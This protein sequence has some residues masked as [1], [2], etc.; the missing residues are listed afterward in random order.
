MPKAGSEKKYSTFIKGFVTEASPLTYPA[1]ASLDEDNFVLNRNGSRE[2]RLGI[3]YETGY[4]ITA[5]GLPEATISG[6]KQSYHRWDSPGGATDVA[7]GIVRVYDKLWFLDLLTAS[8]SANL[9]NGGA[10]ISIAGLANAEIETAVINNLLVI[11]SSDLPI[12]V[13]LAYDKDL[14]EVFQ[15]T[16]P[17]QIRDFFGVNDGL[18]LDDRPSTLTKLHEYNLRNQGWNNKIQAVCAPVTTPATPGTKITEAQ[19]FILLATGLGGTTS[20]LP[21]FQKVA[22]APPLPTNAIECT[23]YTLGVYPSNSDIWTLGKTSDTTVIA[24]FEKY[25]PNIL[26]KN[27]V[28]IVEAPKGCHIIDAFNRGDSRRTLLGDTT[29]PLDSE[30]G[31]ISTVASYAGRV[32][33]SGVVSDITEQDAKSPNYSNYIFFSQIVTTADK[34]GK[35]YQE[36]DPTSPDISDIIDTDGGIIQIPE[37]TRIYRIMSTNTSLLV[38]AENGVWELFGDTQG[39]V[40]TSYQTSKIGSV[41]T[42]SPKSFVSANGSVLGFNKA[43]IYAY[44]PDQV[45]GRY[46]GE[47]ISLTSIQQF[48]NDLSSLAKNNARGFYDEKENKVRWL[49]NDTDSYA[50]GVYENRYNRELILDLTLQAF[51]PHTIT[52]STGPFVADYIDIPRYAVS[53][54]TEPIYVGT[55]PVIVTS[56]DPVVVDNEVITNRSTQFA[57]LTIV[58]TGFTVSKYNNSSFT[59]WEVFFGAGINY[60]S[61]LLTGYEVF[62][63]IMRNKQTPYIW[64]YFDKTEDGF[65]DVGGNLIEDNPSSCIVQAQWNWANSPNSGKWGNSFQAYRFKRNYI[66]SGTGDTFDN[67]DRVVVTKNKLRG[68]GRS[69]SLYIQS[70]YGKDMK[71]LGWAVLVEGGSR[72]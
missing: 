21:H 46:K 48:Y 29:L 1:D 3:D 52:T 67:G 41:G 6:T 16:V 50:A 27:S 13:V 60:S 68:S 14:D 26:L 63:D 39:F 33:Y 54:G 24:N 30:N 2:R 56:G 42:S 62:D 7:I 45:S 31:S 43:G 53:T 37:A 11:V 55:D 47:S 25:D 57:F 71:L 22:A 9:L 10:S 19:L 49:I 20:K 12:P 4:A 36:A 8:P 5:T 17:I 58:S 38:F 32:F 59:D 28:S 18:V 40:A 65:T 35:C 51:Y 72:P 70:E 66:P 61:Y 34:V 15:T 64:F 23:K 69:L 44:V